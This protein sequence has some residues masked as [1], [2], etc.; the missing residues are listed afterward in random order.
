MIRLSSARDGVARQGLG[1]HHIQPVAAAISVA[2]SIPIPVPVSIAIIKSAFAGRVCQVNHKQPL[3][4]S[5]HR[6]F[7]RIAGDDHVRPGPIRR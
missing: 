4:A 5:G 6:V 3:L 7:L 2:V 1:T